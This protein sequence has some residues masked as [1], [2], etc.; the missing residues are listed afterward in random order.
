MRDRTLGN[1]GLRISEVGFGCGTGAG[2][3]MRDEFEAQKA[4][5]ARALELG[6]TYFDTAPIYGDKTSETYLARSLSARARTRSWSRRSP[7]LADLDDIAASV[8]A[9]VEGS[10]DA[11]GAV[12]SRSSTFTTASARRARQTGH[13]CRRCSRSRTC[14]Q[15]R[16]RRGL[17]RLRKRSLVNTSAAV[18]SAATWARLA[19]VST[20]EVRGDAGALQHAQANRIPRSGRRQRDLQLRRVAARPQP[21]DGDREPARARGR[22]VGQQLT[23][24]PGPRSTK[25]G[26]DALARFLRNSDATLAGGIRFALANP[27]VVDRARRDFEVGHV[28]AAGGGGPRP[29]ARRRARARRIAHATSLRH[30][31]IGM[32]PPRRGA[33]RDHLIIGQRILETVSTMEVLL[34]HSGYSTFCASRTTAAHLFWTLRAGS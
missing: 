16:D 20:A 15:R 33:G 26:A 23:E 29:A 11:C 18:R 17:E 21:A 6:I 13:R 3:M 4:A 22:A 9:S 8:V 30:E 19:K 2:L 32:T 24:K 1:T 7:Q 10:L 31:D 25:S 27:K 28:D 5:V 12:R 14:S 34:F